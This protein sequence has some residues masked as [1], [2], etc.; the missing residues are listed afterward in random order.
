MGVHMHVCVCS[1]ALMF[2][3]VHV[4][5]CTWMLGYMGMQVCV[6]VRRGWVAAGNPEGGWGLT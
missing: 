5:A 6:C 2:L 4:C 1:E 3:C